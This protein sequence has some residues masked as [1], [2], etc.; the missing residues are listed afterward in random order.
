V[1]AQ[2]VSF[3]DGA[4][5]PCSAA[6]ANCGA[7]FVPERRSFCPECGQDTRVDPPPLREWAQQF[8]GAYIS[9]E[10]ALWRT[11]RL[12]LTRPGELTAQYLA[13]RRKH[14]VL[15]LR[16]Y[17]TISVLLLLLTRMVGGLEM[18]PGL[19]KPEQVL[20][21][22]GALPTLVLE[23]GPVS[24]GIREGQFICQGFP[25]WV[26]HVVRDRAAPDTRTYLSKVRRANERVQANFGAVLFVLLPLFAACLKAVNR[27]QRMP[28]SAHLVFALHLHAFWFIVLAVMQVVMQIPWQPIV[29]VGV[30]VMAGYTLMAGRLVYP[31]RWPVRLLR[32]GALTLLY[33]GLLFLTVPLAWFLALVW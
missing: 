10:G 31:G 33:M 3:T 15:P 2:A 20:A 25:G 8:G 18:V 4:S 19:D 26:C 1:T 24:L 29:W 14:Y 17:L 6:C 32:A 13:G 30:A 28:Y 21:E 11:L 27:R 7:P 9:T 16:L 22:R 23:A 5:G 12:L